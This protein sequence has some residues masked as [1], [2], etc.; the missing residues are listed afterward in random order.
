MA[1]HKLTSKAWFTILLFSVHSEFQ[2]FSYNI[3]Q[4]K[5][6]IIAVNKSDNI[7]SIV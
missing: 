6:I 7:G 5:G 4:I 2:H 1:M 3:C